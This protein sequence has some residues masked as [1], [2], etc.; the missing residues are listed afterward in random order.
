[1]TLTAQIIGLSTMISSYQIYN[2][3]KLIQENN[4]QDLAL[5]SEYGRAALEPT[6]EPTDPA[7]ASKKEVL[8]AGKPFQRL[9]FLVRDWQNF[10]AELTSVTPDTDMDAR[11][12]II[13]SLVSDMDAYIAE[14]IASRKASDLQSTRTQVIF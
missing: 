13:D 8:V 6:L 7:T 1:M 9:Q 4:L 11:E 5:F 2:V 14:V 10:D 3:D 12:S